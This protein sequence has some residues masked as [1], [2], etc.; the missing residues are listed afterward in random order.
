MKTILKENLL[1]EIQTLT[2]ADY[3][4]ILNIW[5]VSVRA[6]H[7]FLKPGEIEFYKPLILKYA[8]P[9]LVHLF[10]IRQNN[11]LCGF[12]GLSEQKIEML[13]IAPEYFCRGL[14]SLLLN[15]AVMLG[16]KLVDVNEENPEALKFYQR[17][18][19]HVISRDEL[20]DNGKP[21][22]ILHLSL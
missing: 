8:L 14:G 21:H 5:E 22:P 6:T 1:P 17:R 11:K 3:P 10:G 12:I 13:F 2:T 18:G 20:D 15:H 4:E 19:F 7:H 16:Y 9:E